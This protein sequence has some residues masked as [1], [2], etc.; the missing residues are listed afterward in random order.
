MSVTAV[1]LRPIT[2]GSVSKLWLGIL[3]A[4]VIAIGLALAGSAKFKETES[5]LR[6]QVIRA[7]T[8][9][10]PSR[11]DFALVSY[12]GT[13]P[14]GTVFDQNERTPMEIGNVVPG[15]AEALTMMKKGGEM[16]VLIPAELAYGASPPPG[17]S[18]PANADLQFDITLIEFK[19]RQEVMQMQQQMQLQQMLQGQGGVP[20]PGQ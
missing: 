13:L 8:G 17:S 2:K 16:R 5:G 1:P 10:S 12:K 7:G 20:Q 19:T 11:E 9:P 6:Y 18:I 3:I 4:F 14:D 15:F